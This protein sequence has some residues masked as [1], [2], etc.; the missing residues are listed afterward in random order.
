MKFG[1]HAHAVG[2]REIAPAGIRMENLPKSGRT[3]DQI[4]PGLSQILVET[5]E[6]RAIGSAMKTPRILVVGSLVMDHII[7]TDIF[8]EEGAT[9]LGASFATAPG[10]K[11]ANQAVQ[12]ARLGADVT[13]VGKLGC[14]ASGEQLLQ[15]CRT[16]GIHTGHIRQ[17]PAWH[18]GC[19][20]ILLEQTP[21]GSRNRIIVVP[22]ANMAITPE[23]ILFLKEEIAR[24]DLLMLQLEIPM[25]IN[26][27]AARWAWEQGVPVML[28]P[29]PSAPLDGELLSYVTYLSP[30]EHEAADLA[31]S[32]PLRREN[33]PD[34]VRIRTAAAALRA[35]GARNVLITLGDAGA[36]LD[37][38]QHLHYSPC[39]PG[40]RAVDPTAA[41]DSFVA[42]FCVGI[43]SGYSSERALEFA[44][45]T[46]ALTVSAMGAMPSLPTI[47]QVRQIWTEGGAGQ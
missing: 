24:Y 8:P 9:V 5:A 23:D 44:N 3:A 45:C 2:R 41:G 10:G 16:V 37:N 32:P 47:E 7:A 25:E 19:A 38:G 46:A 33:E 29:A 21:Q 43:C 18:S 27:L 20:A 1:I 26:R 22:G 13:L 39:V 36:V 30:N 6:R 28:N 17:D 35:R 42:A 4:R 15:A 14:D 11:G 31:G 40:V 12:A 34:R